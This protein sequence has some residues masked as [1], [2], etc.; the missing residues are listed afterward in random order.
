MSYDPI[1]YLGLSCPSGGDVYI[2]QDSEVR[3]LGCCDVDPC[4]GSGNGCPASAVRPTSFDPK[5]YALIPA[6]A[7]VASTKSAPWYT[8]TNGPTFMGCCASNPCDNQGVCPKDDLVGAALADDSSRASIFLTTATARTSAKSTTSST[9]TTSLAPPISTT[10]STFTTRS[11]SSI[12]TT[13]STFT[14]TSTSSIKATSSTFPTTSTPSILATSTPTSDPASTNPGASGT[15]IGG[16][17]GGILGGL[18]VLGIIAFVFLRYRRR[19]RRELEED[20]IISSQPPWSPYRDAF[21]G[22]PAL[23]PSPV[24]P[25]SSASPHHRSFSASLSSIIG[26]KRASAGHKRS[27]HVSSILETSTGDWAP[28][29]HDNGQRSPDFLGPVE[30]EDQ[31][32]SGRSLRGRLD[33]VVYHEVLGSIPER[34]PKNLAS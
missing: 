6:E 11:T 4:N 9:F 22:S 25:L 13:S 1:S 33:G 34:G 12:K 5:K 26:F 18:V 19:R 21:G 29:P 32:S 2:C 10:S 31:P 3:F 17:V 14:I 20:I 27:S 28:V 16:I 23:Q 24:S 30:L 15:P 7:C 8:C